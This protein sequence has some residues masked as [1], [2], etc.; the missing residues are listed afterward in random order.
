MRKLL[1]DTCIYGELVVDKDLHLLQEAYG[2]SKEIVVYGYSLIR[3]ELRATSKRKNYLNRNLRILLLSL[4]DSFVHER[5]LKTDEN[6]LHIIAHHYY[7]TYR[8]LGGRLPE[9]EI[10]NDYLIVACAAKKGMDLVVSNDHASLL[11]EFS[12]RAY[13]LVNQKLKLKNPQF[14][15]YRGFKSLLL[16]F[17]GGSYDNE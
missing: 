1:V 7:L 17:H 13:T 11:S 6:T 3:K 4:Y 9:S 12:L 10:W 8:Q 15:D 2:C 16:G 5:N 14:I